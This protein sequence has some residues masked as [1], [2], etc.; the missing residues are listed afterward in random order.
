MKIAIVLLVICLVIVGT[1]LIREEF[2]T[3]PVTLTQP[4]P[5]IRQKKQEPVAPSQS[6]TR[7]KKQEPSTPSKTSSRYE[8]L[9]AMKREYWESWEKEGYKVLSVEQS[10]DWIS[11]N[12]PPQALGKNAI[13]YLD[14][15]VIEN[16]FGE[17]RVLLSTDTLSETELAEAEKI[18]KWLK[19]QNY[20]FHHAGFIYSP[21]GTRLFSVEGISPATL[22]DRKV[23]MWALA[24]SKFRISIKGIGS[25]AFR[26][27]T[28][29][30]LQP[31]K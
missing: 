6:S 31:T 8:Q 2:R 24:S 12:D 29:G 15:A 10:R 17:R 1:F 19:E 22:D 3:R 16:R 5:S 21:N 30:E 18:K 11:K 4:K 14:N 23:Q 20:S 7:Q 26:I 9:K 25:A 28:N 13:V 27:D